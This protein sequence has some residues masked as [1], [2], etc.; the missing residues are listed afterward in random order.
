MSKNNS[1]S[2]NWKERRRFHA[3]ELKRRGWKQADIAIALD[4]SK[5][6][7][8]QWISMAKKG[9][10]TGLVSQPHLGRPPE[11]SQEEK[12]LLPDYLWHGAEAYGFR[13]EVWTCTRVRKVIELEF[14]IT[15]HRSHVARLLK[16]LHWTPQQ[17]I[18]RA[19]QRDEEEIAHWRKEVWLEVQKKARLEHRILVFVDESGFYLLPAAIRTYAPCGETPVLR[20]FQTRDHLSMMSGITPHGWLFTMTR[21]DSLNGLDSAHFLKHL[22]ARIDG[23]L[24]VIWD[25]SPIHRGI[26][27]RTF[28][29]EGAAKQIHLERLPP[30]APDLNPD[31]GT[32]RHLKRVELRNVCCFDLDHLHQQIHLAILRLRR[33]PQLIQSFFLQAGLQI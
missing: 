25:G 7:V 26:D 17:P 30:Y 22:Q 3:L 5:G 19:A 20:V 12:R 16:D 9:G 14:G 18:E 13:G 31:E 10:L 23:K 6:A 27:V 15:Y 24:L 1:R 2:S 28:L 8:S 21:F 32:W 4:V 29:A 33:K 11:L